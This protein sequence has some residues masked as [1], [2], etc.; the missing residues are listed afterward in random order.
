MN[1]EQLINKLKEK[2]TPKELIYYY[3]AEIKNKLQELGKIKKVLEENTY[4]DNKERIVLHFVKY[5]LYL[6]M[7]ISYS[8]Y[9]GYHASFSDTKLVKPYQETITLYK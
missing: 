7:I 2:V 1:Y 8:S 9:S 6:E 3:N 5:D 4:W